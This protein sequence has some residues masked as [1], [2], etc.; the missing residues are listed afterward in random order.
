MAEGI[1]YADED[2]KT[3][4]KEDD[5]SEKKPVQVTITVED[6]TPDSPQSGEEELIKPSANEGKETNAPADEENVAK[7]TE[8]GE[9][10][11]EVTAQ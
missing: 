7:L 6:V 8:S 5:E 2:E 11:A 10:T 3:E 9:I 4:E 1:M